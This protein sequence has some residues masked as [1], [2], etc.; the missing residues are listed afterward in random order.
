[1][2]VAAYQALIFTVACSFGFTAC[3]MSP[4]QN[5][6][7]LHTLQHVENIEA[8]PNTKSNTATLNHDKDHCIIQ[9]TGYFDGGESTETWTFQ[10]QQLKQ[11]YSET[12]KYNQHGLVD[13]VTQKSKLDLNSKVKSVFDIQSPETK[14]NFEK[15]KSHFNKDTL[16]QCA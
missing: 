5:P 3:S 15:L 16:S 4:S 11:A 13:T 8:V 2:A 14:N 1:M 12:Y 9:F 6:P 7:A 10:A